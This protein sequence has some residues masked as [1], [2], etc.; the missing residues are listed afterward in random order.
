MY[1]QDASKGLCSRIRSIRQLVK[2]DEDFLAEVAKEQAELA[3]NSVLL[4]ST[5]PQSRV[6][7]NSSD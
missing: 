6:A 3:N 1:F 4:R 2:V 7:Q 5:T